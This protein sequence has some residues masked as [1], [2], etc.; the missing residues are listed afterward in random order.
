MSLSPVLFV[1]ILVLTG[2]IQFVFAII[3]F[4]GILGLPLL[5]LTLPML[6]VRKGLA[7]TLHYFCWRRLPESEREL[8][9]LNTSL[10][11]LIPLFDLY[12]VFVTFPK[13]GQAYD[14]LLTSNELDPGMK[15]ENLGLF[16]ACAFVAEFC[17]AWVPFMS[18][19]TTILV[20][21]AFILYYIEIM[22]ASERLAGNPGTLLPSARASSAQQ[23][24]STREV[25]RP[26]RQLLNLA[27]EHDGKLSLAQISMNIDLSIEDIHQLLNDA[28]KYGYAEM[29]NHPETGAIRYHFDID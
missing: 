7:V 17:L 10:F 19:A 14:R 28:Q 26:M 15:K 2:I 9:P 4:L 3:G 16:F 23:P 27:K 1:I 25:N 21:V 18:S 29:V 24:G 22:R 8:D 13:L 5:L 11:L 6:L 12:W 20:F